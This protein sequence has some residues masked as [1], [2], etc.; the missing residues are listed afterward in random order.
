MMT[1][2][3]QKSEAV[4]EIQNLLPDSNKSTQWYKMKMC[5]YL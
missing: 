4:N 1:V 3:F 5:A 2:I